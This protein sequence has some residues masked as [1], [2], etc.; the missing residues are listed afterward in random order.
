MCARG[1]QAVGHVRTPRTGDE[2]VA[3]WAHRVPSRIEAEGCPSGAI[4]EPETRRKAMSFRRE[5]KGLRQNDGRLGP[6]NFTRKVM[7]DPEPGQPASAFGVRT[8]RHEA[9][10]FTAHAAL[11]VSARQEEG[12][13]SR[14]NSQGEL[15]AQRLGSPVGGPN[16]GLLSH[17]GPK[18][19][20]VSQRI[21][22]P[23]SRR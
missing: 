17:L 7:L 2:E 8:R 15:R 18:G 23:P 1:V 6:A 22:L 13:K 19:H 3:H 4:S 20:V 16:A 9:Q 12:C 14:I 10:G 5:T 21:M 11:G